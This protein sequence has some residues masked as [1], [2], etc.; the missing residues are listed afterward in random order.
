MLGG[1]I[2]LESY[3]LEAVVYYSK[4]YQAQ[5]TEEGCIKSSWENQAQASKSPIRGLAHDM[6]DSQAMTAA[7]CAECNN[8]TGSWEDLSSW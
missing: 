3:I 2:G 5:S 1:I 4:W 6:L 8:L 7:A